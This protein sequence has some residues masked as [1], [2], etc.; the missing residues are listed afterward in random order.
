MGDQHIG[1]AELALQ[2]VQQGEDLRLH[3]HV[4]C[5]DWLIEQQHLW[6]KCQRP[7]NRHALALATR[8]F[9]GQA[10]EELHWQL[11]PCDQL[12]RLAL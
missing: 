10:I 4:Q 9:P 6:L 3:R 2:F 12:A 11:H 1:H 8:Q 5:T 7:C